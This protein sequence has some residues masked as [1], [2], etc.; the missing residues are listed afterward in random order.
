MGHYLQVLIA[1]LCFATQGGK[2]VVCSK[3]QV[4]VVGMFYCNTRDPEYNLCARCF[5]VEGVR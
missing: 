4:E 2:Y 3:C 5:Q 1:P